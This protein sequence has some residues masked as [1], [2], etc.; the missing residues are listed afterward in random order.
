M[1]CEKCH[2]KTATVCFTEVIN[3]HKKEINLCEDCA[4]EHTPY[5]ENPY[6]PL[7]F[8]DF[9]KKIFGIISGQQES[10]LDIPLD[11]TQFKTSEETNYSV[12]KQLSC[13]NCGI[14]LSEFKA[15]TRFGCFNDYQVFQHILPQIF[16]YIHGS[17][18]HIGKVPS[19]YRSAE[20]SE[21]Y[22]DIE[23]FIEKQATQ[24]SIAQKVSEE[25]KQHINIL[26][27][28]R[29]QLKEA[30]EK[31]WYEKAA[32]INKEIKKLEGMEL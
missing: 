15:T 19:A 10:D 29:R 24:E 20:E 16:K 1:D 14:K 2:K 11:S 22:T 5:I 3:Q 12:E 6:S 32:E 8:Q 31:E 26:A 9:L 4:K 21:K 27:E 17:S 25:H 23:N 18:K 28:L 30:I 7:P 13:P